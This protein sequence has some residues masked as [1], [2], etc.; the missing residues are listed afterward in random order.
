M[1]WLKNHHHAWSECTN[2]PDSKN[3]SRKSYT[4]I[5]VS[6]RYENDFLKKAKKMAKHEKEAKW[7]LPYEDAYGQ[8]SRGV[9]RLELCI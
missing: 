1:G 7:L 5:P 6:K 9:S 3:F 2:N 8:D 4:E